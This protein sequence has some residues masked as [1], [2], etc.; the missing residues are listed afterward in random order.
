MTTVVVHIKYEEF[1]QYQNCNV[2]IAWSSP[3]NGGHYIQISLMKK[4]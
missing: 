2:A 3:P 1:V 4:R